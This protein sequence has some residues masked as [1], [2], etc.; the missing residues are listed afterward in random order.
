MGWRAAIR[1]EQVVASLWAYIRYEFFGVPGLGEFETAPL[2]DESAKTINGGAFWATEI[3]GTQST[4]GDVVSGGQHSP[5]EVAD[6]VGDDRADSVGDDRANSV[7]DELADDDTDVGVVT[8]SDLSLDLL[9]AGKNDKR[10]SALPKTPATTDGTTATTSPPKDRTAAATVIPPRLA[11]LDGVPTIVVPDAYGTNILMLSGE[12]GF[13]HGELSARM[14]EEKGFNVLRIEVAR[15]ASGEPDATT[16]LQQLNKALDAGQ[17]QLKEGDTINLSMEYSTTFA[18]VNKLLGLDIDAQNVR[19]RRGEILSAAK[20]KLDDPTVNKMNREFLRT[21][22]TLN[23]EIA[24]LQARGLKVVAA[25]GNNGP[26][27]FN[28]G[29]MNA[30]AQYAAV[31]R[32]GT[33]EPYSARNSLTTVTGQGEVSFYAMPM[34]ALDPTPIASQSGVYR[35]GGTNIFLSTSE[36]GP[37]QAPV[38]DTRI[39][40]RLLFDETKIDAG[41]HPAFALTGPNID[42]WVKGNLTGTVDGTSFVNIF[43]RKPAR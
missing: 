21:I 27:Q 41:T 9:L 34:R 31:R 24:K 18:Y 33:F 29:M 11:H 16:T 1:E 26:M 12:R 35:L 15:T 22:V 13:S 19:E 17:V 28:I 36:F 5:D 25:G 8:L 20:A 37:L 2:R 3:E 30:D 39:A 40:S 6:S 10:R 23:E 38:L 43:A 4:T 42:S 7:G 32:D 14:A